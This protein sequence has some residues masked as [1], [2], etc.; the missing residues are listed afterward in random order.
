MR[1]GAVVMSYLF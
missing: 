1:Y